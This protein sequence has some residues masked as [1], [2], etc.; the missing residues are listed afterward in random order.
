MLIAMCGYPYAGKST[1][2][3]I[4]VKHLDNYH[5]V[6]PSDWYGDDDPGMDYKIACWEYAIEKCSNLLSANYN[7]TIIIL[8]TCGM[9][10]NGIRQVNAMAMINNHYRMALYIDTPI[11]DCKSRGHAHIV[12]SYIDRLPK[13]LE[14]YREEFDKLIRIKYKI[15]EEWGHTS[16][17]VAQLCQKLISIGSTQS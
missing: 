12:E 5:L 13:A 9:V 4:L 8:D 10:S 16:D 15:E 2:C 11:D 3:D 6:R 14:Y 1:F 7:G 17:K